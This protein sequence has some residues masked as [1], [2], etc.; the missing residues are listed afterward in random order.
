MLN[1]RVK[2][3]KRILYIHNLSTIS[4]NY[5]IQQFELPPAGSGLREMF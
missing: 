1:E 5:N 2:R 3:V 4:Y